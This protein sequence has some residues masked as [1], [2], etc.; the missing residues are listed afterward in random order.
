MNVQHL[1]DHVPAQDRE[2]VALL[3]RRAEAV[4][5][6][7]WPALDDV[8]R[9]GRRHVRLRRTAAAGG[10]ALA[11]LVALAVVQG[12]Q[13][14]EALPAAPVPDVTV[15]P[16]ERSA[17]DFYDRVDEALADAGVET[18]R[19]LRWR[20]QRKIEDGVLWSGFGTQAYV[21][22]TGS[23]LVVT[24]LRRE[25][26]AAEPGAAADP[27][28]CAKLLAYYQ[29]AGEDAVCEESDV[30]GGHLVTLTMDE[31]T[32]VGLSTPST[33]VQVESDVSTLGSGPQLE[34]PT[35]LPEE[36]LVE[37]ATDPRLRW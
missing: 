18:D 24:S 6:S 29:Q 11:G 1:D 33:L 4:T 2:S 28:A 35:A 19:G 12:A 9:R 5:P 23:S 31:W 10:V 36:T 14:P 37:L 16:V 27:G 13:R 7:R 17:A 34:S 32:V 25:E 26:P 21:P 22:A 3:R 30:A 20:S 15:V 8:L